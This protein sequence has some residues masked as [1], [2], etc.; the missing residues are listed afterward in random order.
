MVDCGVK[1]LDREQE[2]EPLLRT[3]SKLR[4]HT[5]PRVRY[6]VEYAC[7]ALQLIPD[8]ETF[9][10]GL[11]RNSLALAGGLMKVSGAI[12][13]DLGSV[14]EGLPV[15]IKS[16]RG[17]VDNLK[18]HFG[19]GDKNP[20]FLA[21]RDA[22]ALVS[23]GRLVDF[24]LLICEINCRQDP[25]FQWYICQ[26]LGDMALD[27]S[28]DSTTRE[29]AIKLLGEI[30][31]CNSGSDHHRDVRRWILTILYKISELPWTDPSTDTNSN[32]IK[33][34]AHITYLEL[35]GKGDERPSPLQRARP[36]T[37]YRSSSMMSFLLE[38]FSITPSLELVLD[39]LRF[40]DEKHTVDMLFTSLQCQ[41]KAYKLWTKTQSHYM[42]E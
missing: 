29:Q 33:Q 6:Q 4:K 18:K 16:G 22:E 15:V 17:L 11:T 37:I 39:R 24:N 20:W 2:H 21:V 27:P 32:E 31:S 38:E 23:E 42:D 9:R 40:S 7:R 19:T 12:S 14:P 10:Q 1:D 25:F 41:R 13:L 35:G 26:I 3:L 30:F 28:W 36:V 5:D 8:D 34:Q